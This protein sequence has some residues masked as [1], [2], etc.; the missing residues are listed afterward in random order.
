MTEKPMALKRLFR[1]S[2]LTFL[3]FVT[4]AAVSLGVWT[5]RAKRQ[6]EDVAAI[7]MRPEGY[8]FYWHQ[9]HSDGTV[10]DSAVPGPIWLRQLIGDDY[11]QSV[12]S[13]CFHPSNDADMSHVADLRHV[14]I[15]T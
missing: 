12:R 10:D 2:L 14:E 6:R 7:L 9:L 3:A 13:I 5:Y 1:F 4:T 15:T 11:F 8:V